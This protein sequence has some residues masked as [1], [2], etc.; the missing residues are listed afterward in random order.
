VPRPSRRYITGR[1]FSDGGLTR[2]PLI[3]GSFTALLPR[4]GRRVAAAGGSLR[5]AGNGYRFA[6]VESVKAGL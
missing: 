3:D 5:Y 6:Y 4:A 2:H 1:S